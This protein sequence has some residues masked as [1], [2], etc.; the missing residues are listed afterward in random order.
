MH[1]HVSLHAFESE[2][3]QGNTLLDITKVSLE[4]TEKQEHLAA[5]VVHIHAVETEHCN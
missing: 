2:I 4:C 3:H 1:S 5:V